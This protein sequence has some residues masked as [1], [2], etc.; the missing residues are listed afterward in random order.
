MPHP[1]HPP[2]PPALPGRNRGEWRL[3]SVVQPLGSA[4]IG[5]FKVHQFC[6]GFNQEAT[7]LYDAL[8]ERTV[9]YA[10]MMDPKWLR[11]TKWAG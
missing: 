9:H 8:H 2:P 7:A 6:G 3:G 1:P 5:A 11:S 10:R 4:S